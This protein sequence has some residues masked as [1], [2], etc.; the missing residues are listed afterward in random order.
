MPLYAPIEK[1]KYMYLFNLSPVKISVILHI[2]KL[3]EKF[4]E[5]NCKVNF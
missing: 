5:R 2:C 4:K 3:T 1:C